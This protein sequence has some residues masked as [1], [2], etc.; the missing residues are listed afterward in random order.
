MQVGAKCWKTG[1][2]A[3]GQRPNNF[4]VSC[5]NTQKHPNL[6]LTSTLDVYEYEVFEHLHMLGMGVWVHPSIVTPVQ[7][8]AKFW[9]TRHKV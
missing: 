8:G 6:H 2:R 7:D 4:M 1:G 3:D 9:K 5:L